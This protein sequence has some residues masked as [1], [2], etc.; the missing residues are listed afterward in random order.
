MKNGGNGLGQKGG[1][2]LVRRFAGFSER[3][4]NWLFEEP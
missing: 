4:V 2:A 3:E 1:F